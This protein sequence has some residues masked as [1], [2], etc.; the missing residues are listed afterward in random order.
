[1]V[2]LCSAVA[3]V[4]SGLSQLARFEL[5]GADGK[6]DYRE[7]DMPGALVNMTA[8]CVLLAT[9]LLFFITFIFKRRQA[10]DLPVLF[11][12][13][14]LVVQ[15]VEVV[16]ILVVAEFIFQLVTPHVNRAINSE[17][18]GNHTLTHIFNNATQSVQNFI[19]AASQ[20][21]GGAT[22][23]ADPN[24]TTTTTT[25][26]TTTAAAAVTEA[27]SSIILGASS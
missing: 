23:S 15:F 8:V 14:L 1:M 7:L 10:H 5:T 24:A 27:N 2:V 4:I 22:S 20:H 16:L 3:T 18:I 12:V 17:F 9:V 19:S 11:K 21:L 25:S 13:I 6:A 26:P